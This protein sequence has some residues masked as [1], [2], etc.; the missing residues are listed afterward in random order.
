MEI[1]ENIL[2]INIQD[3]QKHAD[4]ILWEKNHLN[5]FDK[6]FKLMKS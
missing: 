4:W 6:K 1:H 5:H 3:I 2:K